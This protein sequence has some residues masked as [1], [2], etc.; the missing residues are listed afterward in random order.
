MGDHP[1]DSRLAEAARTDQASGHSDA[2]RTGRENGL[3]QGIGQS[4]AGDLSAA[5]RRD[6]P[7]RRN[8]AAL[9]PDSTAAAQT[10]DGGRSSAAK[11]FMSTG[12]RPARVTAASA[13]STKG[14]RS[15]VCDTNTRQGRV[16]PGRS[17]LVTVGFRSGAGCASTG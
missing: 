10:S 12:T 5:Q 15:L 13:A 11:Y 9:E 17:D 2:A 7:D 1:G 4:G 8:P 6:R 16:A 14:P 3:D